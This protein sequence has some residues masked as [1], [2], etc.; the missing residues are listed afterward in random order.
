MWNEIHRTF[1]NHAR[2]IE[3]SFKDWKLINSR[4]RGLLTQLF[5]KCQMCNYETNIWSEPVKSET[6]DINTAATAGTVTAGIGY[7]QFE[8]LCAAMNIPCM[9]EKTYIKHRENLIDDF[10]KTALENMKIA[11]EMEKQ[12]AVKRN[13]IINGIPY[14]TVIA[15]G[16]WMKRSYGTAYDSLSGVG[17]IIGYSTQKVLFVGIRNKFCT[18]CDIA[19][20]K[21]MEARI[22]K[23]YKNFDRH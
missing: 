17:A 10:E 7:A 6:L 9:S 2:G 16:S 4:H 14:I 18:V 13:E 12:L 20:R 15:D 21:N 23:C 22:H 8:E 11:G 1:D 19:E 3:C 5:F